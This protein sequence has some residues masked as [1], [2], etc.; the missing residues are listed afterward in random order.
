MVIMIVDWWESFLMV[1]MMYHWL[2]SFLMVIMIVALVKMISDG[3]DD[4]GIGGNHF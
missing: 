1:M 2:E 4:S 3:D